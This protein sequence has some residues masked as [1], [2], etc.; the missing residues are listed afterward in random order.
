MA[1]VAVWDASKANYQK[2]VL[3]PQVYGVQAQ[4]Q[5]NG[6]WPPVSS[7]EVQKFSSKSQ[8]S[9]SSL[10]QRWRMLG[11]LSVDICVSYLPWYTFVPIQSQGMAVFGARASDFNIL[12][13]VY[14]LVYVPGVFLSGT[15]LSA[16]GC[17][18]CFTL[19]TSCVTAGCMLRSGPAVF[20]RLFSLAFWD[21]MAETPQE[22]AADL[23]PFAWLVA[24]QTLCALGQTFLVNATSHLAAEWFHPDERPAAA[25]ISNLMNFIG[26]SLAFVLPTW[27]VS[28]EG[29]PETTCHQVTSLLDAQ[30]KISLAALVLTFALYRDA[31]VALRHGEAREELPL[32]SEFGRVLQLRD[33]WLV[34]GQFL[35]YIA[36]L[37]TFDAV[38]GSLLSNYGYSEAL[39]SWTAVSFCICSVVSTAIE[40][41]II[42]HPEQY[43]R[44]LVG[45]NGVLAASCLIGLTVLR[46]QMHRFFFVFAVGVMGF[47]TPGWGCSLEIGSEVCYPVR[48]ATVSS[49]LEAFG[50]MASV[51]GIIVAQQMIDSGQAAMVPI[52][53]A[54]C[55]LG[56]STLLLGLSGRLY[57]REAEDSDGEASREGI[58]L[59][60][61]TDA[62]PESSV[63]NLRQRGGNTLANAKFQIV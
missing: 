4:Y 50:S 41:A 17:H 59:L 43:R 20:M 25:M 42:K 49:L 34:N 12:C 30:L 27:Y 52:G 37:N 16:L 15:L 38:E 7:E 26:G 35:L 32:I 13:I 8:K 55:S 3:E 46:W 56:G 33:F 51:G 21:I 31:P 54:A 5:P 18:W 57:R 19:A 36:V 29:L 22:S 53:F 9:K 1:E 58:E 48:E 39:S 24:G 62:L 63:F 6:A 10:R 23:A 60:D 45:I 47:S 40:S 28:E 11:I 44:A 2:D 61:A 14:S